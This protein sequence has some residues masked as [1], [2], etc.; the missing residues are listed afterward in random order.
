MNPSKKIV[1]NL[2]AYFLIG[3]LFVFVPLF[4]YTI[5]SFVVTLIMASVLVT[6]IY[7]IQKVLMK[8]MPKHP[9]ITTFL[10]ILIVIVI[11][12]IPLIFFMTF[13]VG[14]AGNAYTQISGGLTGFFTKEF[15]IVPAN[16][17]NSP[18]GQWLNSINNIIPISIGDITSNILLF[19]SSIISYLISQ[20]AAIFQKLSIVIVHAIVFFF[21][22]FYFLRDGKKLI[23]FI[24]N[25]LPMNKDQRT[26]MFSRLH[27]INYSMIY[28]SC[29]DALSHGLLSGLGFYFVGIPNAAFWGTMMTLLSP[30][31]YIGA[32]IVWLPAS[33]AIG[34]QGKI[35]YAILLPLWCMFVTLMANNVVKPYL[36]SGATDIHPLLVILVILGGLMSFGFT[37]LVTGLFL[38]S[39]FL[40][41]LDIYKQEYKNVLAPKLETLISKS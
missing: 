31:P 24:G 18:F 12:L 14:E 11:I 34:I 16:L 36:I 13:I 39:L 28:G 27:T 30:I 6:G 20:S 1:D 40:T 32:A 22:M 4:L 41:F 8:R 9:T 3:A 33:I 21:A 29:I 7:P 37:G 10:T 2:G 17:A 15:N 19:F 25:I 5:S 23:D 26:K 35:L 38:L